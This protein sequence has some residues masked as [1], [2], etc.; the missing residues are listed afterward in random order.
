VGHSKDIE[1]IHGELNAYGDRATIIGIYTPPI[2]QRL[3]QLEN[4]ISNY[5]LTHSYSNDEVERI[6]DNVKYYMDENS[7]LLS[8]IVED[9]LYD[10]KFSSSL[11]MQLI[12]REDK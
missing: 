9:G 12:P 11:E 3:E 8:Q 2:E 7:K 10:I 1:P 5:V 4:T 6:K